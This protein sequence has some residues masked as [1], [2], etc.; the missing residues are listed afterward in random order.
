MFFSQR[1]DY[2]GKREFKDE[3]FPARSEQ[4]DFNTTA[5]EKTLVRSI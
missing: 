5:N 1:V 2:F 4:V 3:C